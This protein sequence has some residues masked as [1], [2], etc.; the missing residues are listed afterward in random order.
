M[1]PLPIRRLTS[2]FRAFTRTA[3]DFGG[4]FM[5]RQGQGKPQRTYVG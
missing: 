5:T 3:V 1:A 2:S 4:P